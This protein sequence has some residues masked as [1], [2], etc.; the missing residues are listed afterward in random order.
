MFHALAALLK[1]KGLATS[2][3]DEG[4]FA[5]NLQSDE[6]AIECILDAIK[7]AGYEPENDF[8][9]A[10]DVAASEWKSDQKGCICFQNPG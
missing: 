7:E 5:P 10:I 6:E 2:V 1:R 8:R 4:G 3:G 9:I